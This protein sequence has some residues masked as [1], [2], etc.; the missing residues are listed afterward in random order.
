MDL[1]A[2]EIWRIYVTFIE[3]TL[4]PKGAHS[5]WRRI[6]QIRK[7]HQV[8]SILLPADNSYILNIRKA[9]LPEPEHVAIYKLLNIPPR[10]YDFQGILDQGYGQNSDEKTT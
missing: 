1:S 8:C 5:S 9:S 7:T 10:A 3:N 4:L 2:N 6:R